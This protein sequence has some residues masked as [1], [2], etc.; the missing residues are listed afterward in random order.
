MLYS[1]SLRL[2]S[3]GA[4]ADQ[5]RMV[6]T[7]LFRYP[8]TGVSYGRARTTCGVKPKQLLTVAHVGGCRLHRAGDSNGNL[9]P[10]SITNS[11]HMI[12]KPRQGSQG[13][14][15]LS[16]E[17]FGWLERP[18]QMDL[19]ISFMLTSLCVLCP[20]LDANLSHFRSSHYSKNNKIWCAK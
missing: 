14:S 8:G 7:V 1:Q 2:K 10:G 16:L 11:D 19:C 12:P 20:D 6:L 5:R 15:D 17:Q 18:R 13:C 9:F 3:L 4:R